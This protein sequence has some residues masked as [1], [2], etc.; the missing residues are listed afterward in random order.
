VNIL[1][2]Y[3]MYIIKVI[4]THVNSL[5]LFADR[6]D[7]GKRVNDKLMITKAKTEI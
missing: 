7:L 2:I 1:D 5:D 6:C 3:N 4:I